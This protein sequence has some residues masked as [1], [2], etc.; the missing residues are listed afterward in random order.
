M[1]LRINF[2]AYVATDWST[3][4]KP[5]ISRMPAVVG[6]DESC[7]TDLFFVSADAHP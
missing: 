3:S 7:G 6:L 4:S 2:K 5:V 1:P